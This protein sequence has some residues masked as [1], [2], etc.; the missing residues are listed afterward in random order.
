MARPLHPKHTETSTYQAGVAGATLFLCAFAL[1]ICA[2]HSRKWRACYDLLDDF[3]D[4]PVIQHNNGSME[5]TE[6]HDFQPGNGDEN[7]ASGEQQGVSIW[8]KNVLMGGK[9]QLPDFSGIIIYD[10]EGNVVTPAKTPSLT[11]K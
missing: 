6:V 4:D 7:M 2:S 10:T 11:S 9:C 1:F 3:H 8:Q 5:R